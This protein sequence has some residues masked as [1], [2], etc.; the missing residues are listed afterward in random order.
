M[1]KQ[2]RVVKNGKLNGASFEAF[3]WDDGKSWCSDPKATVAF[4]RRRKKVLDVRLTERE[5]RWID[6]LNQ[7]PDS[8]VDTECIRS[9]VG[10]GH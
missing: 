2:I 4:L 10:Y 8:L 9:A 6:Q 1:M 3:S 7:E 5:L